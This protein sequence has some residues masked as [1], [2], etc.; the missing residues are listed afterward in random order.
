V[1]FWQTSWAVDATL[2]GTYTAAFE[3]DLPRFIVDLSKSLPWPKDAM[4]GAWHP[5][6]ICS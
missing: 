6:P 1:P 5:Q 3:A 2:S 4:Q